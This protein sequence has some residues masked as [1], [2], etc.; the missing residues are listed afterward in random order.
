MMRGTENH[1]RH[2][3]DEDESGGL[4]DAGREQRRGAGLR[5]RGPDQAAD[6]RVR[7]AGR[8][9]VVPGDEIPGDGTD[10]G[11]EDQLIVDEAGIDDPLAHRGGHAQVK[12]E[13]GD[14]VEECRPEDCLPGL[15][16]AGGNH[17]RNGVRRVV[18][19]VH[20]VERQRQRNQQNQREGNRAEIHE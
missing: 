15:E 12:E 5:K 10:Q 17:G 6:E 8:N 14:D 19:A 7:R 2:R 11:A 16:H 20:E 13:H 3:R 18:K 4:D 9:A 1:A